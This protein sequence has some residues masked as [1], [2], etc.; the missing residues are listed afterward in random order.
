MPESYGLVNTFRAIFKTIGNTIGNLLVNLNGS[1]GSDGFLNYKNIFIGMGILCIATFILIYLYLRDVILDESY[2]EQ[3]KINGSVDKKK[4]FCIVVKQG[5]KLCIDQPVVIIG[6]IGSSFSIVIQGVGLSV[7]SNAIDTAYKNTCEVALSTCK[8]QSQSYFADL[9]IISSLVSL[10]LFG[11]YGYLTTK[12]R[13]TFILS[14]SLCIM[15]IA[16]YF[17]I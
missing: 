6:M 11:I 13:L 10:P 9:R 8:D 7:T 5:L 15:L 4:Q 3:R 16:F 1:A 12:F 14:I 2:Q 17:V